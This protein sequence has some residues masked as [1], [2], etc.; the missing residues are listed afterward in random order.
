MLSDSF[1]VYEAVGGNPGG[2]DDDA[3]RAFFK[4]VDSKLTDL[5]DDKIAEFMKSEDFETYREVGAIYDGS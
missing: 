1:S 5:P 2:A 4:L 3:R